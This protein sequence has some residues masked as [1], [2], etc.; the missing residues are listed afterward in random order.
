MGEPFAFPAVMVAPSVQDATP[1]SAGGES[2]PGGGLDRRPYRW[3]NGWND[4]P[5]QD[6]VPEPAPDPVLAVVPGGERHHQLQLRHHHQELAAI[7]VRL[8]HANRPVA[9]TQ[10]VEV[11]GV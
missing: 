6:L 9:G 10:P 7:P 1:D 8:V 2:A 3:P 11:P 5:G 4:L